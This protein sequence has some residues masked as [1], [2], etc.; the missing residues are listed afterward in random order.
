[1]DARDTEE[2]EPDEYEIEAILKHRTRKQKQGK[3]TV[4]KKQYLVRF[5]GYS[6]SEDKWIDE[7]QLKETANKL[8]SDYEAN[9]DEEEKP[10][11]KKSKKKTNSKKK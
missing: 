2:M 1:M 3:K 7:A 8:V 5:K 9:V 6:P 10:R 4:S 11:K